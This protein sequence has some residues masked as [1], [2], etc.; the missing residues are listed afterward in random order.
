MK[1]YNIFNKQSGF[2]SDPS[3]TSILKPNIF[4]K[5]YTL[6]K[7]QEAKILLSELES[8]YLFSVKKFFKNIKI[9]E[10]KELIDSKD[11]YNCTLAIEIIKQYM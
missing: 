10:I 6:S 9:D 3:R 1:E 8:E 5:S 2:I 7:H 4:N 11:E